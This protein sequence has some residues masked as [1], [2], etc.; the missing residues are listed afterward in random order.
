MAKQK[1]PP[2]SEKIAKFLF[3]KFKRATQKKKYTK[4]QIKL[5]SRAFVS[6][7]VALAEAAGTELTME[8]WED[9]YSSLAM[10]LLDYD[11]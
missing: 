11:F 8:E 9:V 6:G 4:A 1:N 5:A 2:K 10:K 7:M 3:G